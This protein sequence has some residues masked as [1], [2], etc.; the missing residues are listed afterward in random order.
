M[1]DIIQNGRASGSVA[2]TLLNN[3]FEVGR[4]RPWVDEESG[5]S[6]VTVN[7]RV[8]GK[9]VAQ[10]ERIADNAATLRKDEWIALD[11][12]CMGVF[13]NRLRLVKDLRASSLV[14]N[15]PGGLG[16]TVLQTETQ[17]DTGPAT[18]SMD[19]LRKGQNDRPEY[20]INSMPLP[21]VHAEFGFSLRQL[22]AS[23]RG[24]TP[25]DTTMME[26][27]SRKVAESLEAL[28]LGTSG[29]AYGGGNIYGLINFPGRMLKTLTLPTASGWTPK[30]TVDDVLAMRQQSM[31]A[32]HYGPWMLYTGVSWDR[33]LDADYSDAKGDN[34]LR[35]RIKDIRGI[36]G[37]ETL[38]YLTGYQMILVQWT[39]DV[40]RTVLGLEAMVLQWEGQG[41][42]ELNFKIL[43]IQVPQVRADFNGKCGIVHGS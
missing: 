23:R 34:T 39:Q 10:A 27:R 8:G 28:H 4:L 14:F 31:D 16:A 25:L 1:I 24:D 17:S 11:K 42:L 21:I 26:Q 35:A 29:Y 9:I 2:A 20:N 30:K 43:T 15:V 33:Y 3:N 6:F 37:I 32:F 40:V 38:D 7:K 13:R 12:V 22:A 41:G 18:I 19:G 5:H 36:Q